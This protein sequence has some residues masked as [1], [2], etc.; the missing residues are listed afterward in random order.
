MVHNF[1]IIS[2][3]ISNIGLC[4]RDSI[5][6]ETLLGNQLHN[7]DF[8]PIFMTSCKHFQQPIFFSEAISHCYAIEAT[9]LY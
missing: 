6:S 8:R 3:S 1:S 7:L 5:V 2:T 9:G 4:L